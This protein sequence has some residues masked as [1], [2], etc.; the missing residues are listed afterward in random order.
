MKS[1]RY[2][3]AI[4]SVAGALFLTACSSN[5]APATAAVNAALDSY[6]AVRA[7]ALQYIPEQA[8]G[9]EDALT[10]AKASLDKGDYDAALNGAKGIPDTVKG[11]AE[12]IAAKKA[13]MTETWKD[14]SGGVG[15]MVDTLQ[16]KIITLMSAKG[17]AWTRPSSIRSG[18][19][20]TQRSRR[21]KM[22]KALLRPAPWAMPWHRPRSPRTRRRQ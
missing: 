20:T 2:V 22:R 16:K 17:G 18:A 9:V 21:G 7:D 4:L 5:K 11:F 14:M 3:V 10:A 6:K 12:P 19:V 15:D 8:K 13:E 1:K